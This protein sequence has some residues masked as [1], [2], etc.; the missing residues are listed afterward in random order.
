LYT[1][2][3]IHEDERIHLNIKTN[4]AVFSFPN[5]FLSFKKQEPK[6]ETKKSQYVAISETNI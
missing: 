5:A 1:Y 3:F 2:F 6:K 4:L